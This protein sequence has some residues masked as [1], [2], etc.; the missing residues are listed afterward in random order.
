MPTLVLAVSAILT[1]AGFFSQYGWGFDLASHFR[2]QYAAVQILC[3]LLCFL[4]KKK[5]LLLLTSVFLVINISQILPLYFLSGMTQAPAGNAVKIKVLVINIHNENRQHEKV[6]AYI[7]KVNPDVL[8]LEEINERWFN[9]LAETLKEFPNKKFVLR[10]DNFGIGLFSKLPPSQMAVE[11]YG[12]AHVPSILASF[13]IKDKSLDFLFTHPLPPASQ[14]YF[15]WRNAQLSEI[16]SLRAQFNDNLVVV[17]DLNTTSWS[18]HFK[19]FQRKMRLQDSRKG[20]GVQVSW[21]TMFPLFGITIDHCLVSPQVRVLTRQVGP[22]IG[23]DHYPVYIEL[24][25]S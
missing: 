24:G 1:I 20:F 14:D 18:H 17:G 12:Q 4:Q 5:R 3:A 13:S 19:D 9:Q 22:D 15:D 8:A 11:Y 2:V 7:K 25:I 16:A 10:E 21:P 6:A 23:S